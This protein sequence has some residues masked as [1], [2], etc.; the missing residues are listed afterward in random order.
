MPSPLGKS[1]ALL[2]LPVV[3]LL[4]ASTPARANCG[5]V[6]QLG[7]CTVS[8]SATTLPFGSYNPTS[9]SATDFDGVIT[10]NATVSGVSAVTTVSYTISLGAGVTGTVGDRRMTGGS[11]G[12]TLQYNLFTDASHNSKWGINGVSNSMSAFVTLGSVGLSASHTVYGRIPV[13]QYV[14]AGTNYTDTI[15]VTVNY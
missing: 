8:V 14:S 6:V 11:G 15:A 9:S 4:L 7:T 5:S 1:C 2:A 13:R 12:P 3:G 10:V